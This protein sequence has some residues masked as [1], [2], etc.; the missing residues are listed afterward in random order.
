MRKYTISTL[1]CCECNT[2][3]YIPRIHKRKTNHRKDMY[4]YVC[5]K[6]NKFREKGEYK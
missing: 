5:K 1:I 2:K 4:C 3:M 6:E